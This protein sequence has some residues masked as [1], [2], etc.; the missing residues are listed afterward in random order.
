M[1]VPIMETE[2]HHLDYIITATAQMKPNQRFEDKWIIDVEMSTLGSNLTKFW[3]AVSEIEDEEYTQTR[4]DVDH[5][6]KI[7]QVAV[8]FENLRLK[9][10]P[11]IVPPTRLVD[12]TNYSTKHAIDLLPQ[13]APFVNSDDLK[14]TVRNKNGNKYCFDGKVFQGL[15]S[16]N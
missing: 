14:L 16:T 11:L 4:L 8:I 5:N 6:L 9:L 10:A 7:D 12:K 3:D 1:S 2:S 15:K 13:W